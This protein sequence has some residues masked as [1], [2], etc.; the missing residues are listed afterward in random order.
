LKSGTV[1]H[2]TMNVRSNDKFK[3]AGIAVSLYAFQLSS[4][5]ILSFP[6]V[7][8]LGTGLATNLA[9]GSIVNLI[10]IVLVSWGFL[11]ATGRGWLYVD[12]VLVDR[13]TIRNAALTG[14][15]VVA[16]QQLA[17]M[18][19]SL[20]GV[21]PASI[22]YDQVSGPTL[23]ALGFAVVVLTPPIEELFFR[24]IIQKRLTEEFSSAAAIAFASLIF[25]VYHV[26]NYLGQPLPGIA[27]A[28][29]VIVVE[30]VVLGYAYERTGNLYVPTLAHLLNN[31]VV[32]GVTY[33][34]L[35][36]A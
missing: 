22:T 29:S 12:F 1:N 17:S 2:P 25:A 33:A 7:L 35:T 26:P 9:I 5:T 27:A 14:V 3:T 8:L 23:L 34:Q 6:L 11:Y 24:N 18:L 30:A 36:G 4:L 32:F 16:I 21:T 13:T 15:A 20:L 31:V 19:F 10:S 28:V